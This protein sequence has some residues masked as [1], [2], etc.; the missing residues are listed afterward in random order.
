MLYMESISLNHSLSSKDLRDP[1]KH[2]QRVHFAPLLGAAFPLASGA[3]KVFAFAFALALPLAPAFAAALGTGMARARASK[4]SDSW[5]L[6][7][8]KRISPRG[9]GKE[10]LT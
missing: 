7:G 3:G 2:L 5:A 1:Q 10:R 6:G 8:M 9:I 4:F